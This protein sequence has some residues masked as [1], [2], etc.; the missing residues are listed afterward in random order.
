MQFSSP[1]VIKPFLMDLKHVKRS[2][3]DK[4]KIE[5]VTPLKA[6]EYRQCKPSAACKTENSIIRSRSFNTSYEHIVATLDENLSEKSWTR[7]GRKD[8]K[9]EENRGHI[10][11]RHQRS[12][13]VDCTDAVRVSSSRNRKL[14]RS[15]SIPTSPLLT[16]PA[17]C[18]K[19]PK[20]RRFNKKRQ[21]FAEIDLFN[22]IGEGIFDKVEQILKSAE[23]NVNCSNEDGMTPLDIASLINHVPL[24]K[25]LLTFGAK[26]NFNGIGKS[27]K[28]LEELIRKT[29]HSMGDGMKKDDD[30]SKL[31]FKLELLRRMK[32]TLERSKLPNPPS[33]VQLSVRSVDSLLVSFDE[34]LPPC[35]AITVKYKIEWSKTVSFRP[36]AGSE[37]VIGDAVKC[38]TIY[39]LQTGVPYYVRVSFGNV[40]GF[41]NPSVSCPLFAVPSN[42]REVE[43]SK[44]RMEGKMEEL[45]SLLI[46][47]NCIESNSAT[48][49]SKKV[50]IVK[51]SLKNLFSSTSRFQRHL[52]RGVYLCCLVYQTDKVLLTTDDY[53]PCV[54][55][56]ENATLTQSD[57]LWFM[58]VACSWNDVKQLKS[59]LEKT[60][61]GSLE[62]RLKLL[63]AIIQLQTSLGISDLGRLRSIP[64]HSNGV[65]ILVSV[66][67]LKST[68]DVACNHAKWCSI[69]KLEKR[70]DDSDMLMTKTK[71]IIQE[72]EAGERRLKEGLYVAY[73]KLKC[74][75]D[76]MHV[77]VDSHAP[78]ILPHQKVRDCPNITKDEWVFLKNMGT[79]ETCSFLDDEQCGRMICFQKKLISACRQLMIRLGVKEDEALSHRLYDVEAV[80]MS[81]GITLI[82]ILPPAET[83]C[84]IPGN[85]DVCPPGHVVLPVQAFEMA[86]AWTYEREFIQK[87]SHLSLTVETNLMLSQQAQREAF[88]TKEL[89]EAKLRVDRFASIRSQLEDVWR[90]TRWTMDAVS[91]ARAKGQ[92]Q[93]V[94][95]NI[96]YA[97]IASPN[98]SPTWRRSDE[99][100]S[101]SCSTDAGYQS[102]R[103]EIESA[104]LRVYA[105]YECGLALGSCV[106]L[107]VTSR[108]TARKVVQLVIQQLNRAVLINGKSGP[109]Y[110]DD[111][112][113]DF[114]LSYVMHG[115]ERIIAD[116]HSPISNKS[117]SQ[118]ARF[119]VRPKH[120]CLYATSV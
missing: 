21:P 56:E 18:K 107:R 55:V 79:P 10:K 87:Y 15:S 72:H 1:Y 8:Q 66:L 111:E 113:D 58:K 51:K 119:Y 43:K 35:G 31:N 67:K 81:D 42:W 4:S 29:I 45:D 37:V 70:Y 64:V 33:N 26:E 28:M 98:E 38:F 13:S 3:K 60:T 89:L 118:K 74:S 5:P 34:P 94:P 83:L 117:A 9:E 25:L 52:R 82:L 59:D 76:K 17:A 54:E 88:S 97:T 84:T 2:W 65:L 108:T 120:Q 71:E 7:L 93:G 75:L 39:Q 116:H 41:S 22:A 68:K 48:V 105:A 61:S 77:L 47:S 16:T 19:S 102:D 114:C 78:N 53:L 46:D 62:S 95:L 112:L 96:L 80:E 32:T 69:S 99:G 12:H 85:T 101:R 91:F 49:G 104:T 115:I 14:E 11:R 63:L 73:L 100:D 90:S 20:P 110:S 24:I 36:L 6:V 27:D 57:L 92:T 40:K 23:V 106:K 109:I 103:N 86:Y 30:F 50:T 44:P